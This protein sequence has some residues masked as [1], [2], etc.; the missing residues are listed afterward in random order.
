MD[1]SLSKV[2]DDITGKRDDTAKFV[3]DP[4][5]DFSLF[6]KQK[7]VNGKL[8]SS[9]IFLDESKKLYMCSKE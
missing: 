5:L 7:K 9:Q 1:E 2:G 3:K 4:I 8:K 6:D